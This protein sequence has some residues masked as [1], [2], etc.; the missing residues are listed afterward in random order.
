VIGRRRVVEFLAKLLATLIQGMVGQQAAQQL[1]RHVADAGLRLLGLEAERGADGT[2]GA[3]ALVATAEDTI[4]EVL[5]LP[6]E[7]IDN[8]LLLEAAVQDAFTAAAVRHFPAE[9]LRP[10]LAPQPEDGERGIWLMFPR[11]V[12]PHYRY[13]KYTVVQPLRL[14]RPLAR[15]VVFIDGETLEDRLLDAGVRS[16]PVPA[17][18]HFYELMPGA[19]LGH[20][21]AF[22]ADGA[23]SSYAEA[24]REFDQLAPDHPQPIAYPLDRDH[25]GGDHWGGAHPGAPAGPGAH[26]HPHPGARLVRIV[27]RGLRLPH[28]SPFSLRLDLSGPKPRLRLH[29]HLSE[30]VAHELVE[31]L[32]KQ[33]MAQVVA[34]IRRRVGEPVRQA[35]AGRLHRMLTR[36]GITPAEGASARLAA[37][38]AEAASRAVARQLPAAAT[39]LSAA[40]RDQ[41]AGVTLTFTFGFSD[42]QAIAAAKGGE[43]ELS[44]RRGVHRD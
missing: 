42:R 27:V 44:I 33:R 30:R 11:A 39:A 13:K 9:V 3:E 23:T 21:A 36:H 37:W 19:E 7:S 38:L 25:P 2:L 22:E 18:A 29:L 14:T 43:P 26:R 17:E 32:A 34:V 20:L 41:A 1:S 28:R 16:W 8:E 10:D 24:A 40:A 15:A 6:A 5:A 4:R 35:L 12:R 31:H